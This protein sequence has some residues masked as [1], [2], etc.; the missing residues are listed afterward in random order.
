LELARSGRGWIGLGAAANP[1]TFLF[2]RDGQLGALVAWA[3]SLWLIGSFLAPGT[4]VN[5]AVPTDRIR[6]YARWAIGWSVVV[7]LHPSALL[8]FVALAMAVIAARGDDGHTDT[9][10]RAL[11]A[12]ALGS[13][14][15]LLPW[16]IE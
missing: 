2:L 8:A 5:W 10:I 1:V 3:G 13:T 12:G 16:S 14:L 6:F 15:L 11:V 9:R 7:A 4:G